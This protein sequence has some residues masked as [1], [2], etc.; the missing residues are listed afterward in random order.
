MCKSIKYTTTYRNDGYK[1][2]NIF[3]ISNSPMDYV[4]NA[5][6]DQKDICIVGIENYSPSIGIKIISSQTD[7]LVIDLDTVSLKQAFLLIKELEETNIQIIVLTEL[8]VD[9]NLLKL[10]EVGL[11]SIVPKMGKSIQEIAKTIR[12]VQKDHFFMP[13]ELIRLFLGEMNEQKITNKELFRDKLHEREIYLTGRE[14]DTA[15]LMKDGLKNKEIS[16]RLGITEGTTKLHITQV[17]KK[18]GSK[19]RKEVVRWLNHL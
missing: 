10:I 5:L 14:F 12:F 19:R 8:T 2:K 15:Y 1:M 16:S 18:I 4:T 13:S 11:D 6:N 3:G 7:M 17:Y 9:P